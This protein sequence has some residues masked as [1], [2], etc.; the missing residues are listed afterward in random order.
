MPLNVT[1]WFITNHRAKDIFF[2]ARKKN[3]TKGQLVQK[4]LLLMLM[5]SYTMGMSMANLIICCSSNRDYF[6]SKKQ[7]LIS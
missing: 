2:I 7:I 6:A 3:F 5:T 4:K 1:L